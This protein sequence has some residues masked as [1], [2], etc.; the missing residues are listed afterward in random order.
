MITAF[1]K[2]KE[3][4]TEWLI[5]G[6]ANW[7]ESVFEKFAFKTDIITSDLGRE[8]RRAVR[9]EPRRY[10]RYTCHFTEDVKLYMDYYMANGLTQPTIIPDLR[11]VL[12]LKEPTTPEHRT[13]GFD[14]SL[15]TVTKVG[16]PTWLKKNMRVVI[17]KGD[18]W[19]TRTV[20][21]FTANSITFKEERI[22]HPLAGKPIDPDNPDGDK[23]PATKLDGSDFPINSRVYPAVFGRFQNT[24][25]ADR[26][27]SDV[28]TMEIDFA[29][30]PTDMY[31][32]KTR[33]GFTINDNFETQPK[34]NVVAG[35]EV[36][37]VPHN[38]AESK[39]FTY[40]DEADVVDYDY[41]KITTFRKYAFPSRTVT[42]SYLLEGVDKIQQF[43]EFFVRLKGR[44]REFLVPTYEAD[45]PFNYVLGNGKSIV[46]D[47]LSFGVA[48]KNSK[49][50]KRIL[51][52]MADG[53]QFHYKVDFV[54]TLPETNSSVL[55]IDGS[56]PD[57]L[58]TPQTI[59]KISWVLVARMGSDEFEVEWLTDT[60][61]RFNISYIVLENRD[62]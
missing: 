22:P 28:Y 31:Q 42:N 58:L 16:Y 2:L 37:E 52:Q 27:T 24:P 20:E 61:A 12:V 59:L 3:G 17:G 25:E 11:R 10:I 39:R 14:A 29:I 33:T 53:R 9:A 36:L 30:N 48:Y 19:E 41:G 6:N 47:G 60:K 21:S 51:L 38:W 23:Y 62:L 1:G 7:A 8:Q 46:M 5:T 57:E 15:T 32:R 44:Q 49:I 4:Q 55:Q 18:Q 35:R 43:I 56:L 45:V 13:S 54:D 40:T 26:V 34:F 50:Y